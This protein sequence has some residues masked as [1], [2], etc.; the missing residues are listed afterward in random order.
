MTKR[1]VIAFLTLVF[2]GAVQA[3]SLEIPHI[4]VKGTASKDVTPDELYWRLSVRN[5]AKETQTVAKEH[6]KIVSNVIRYLKKQGIKGKDIQ[7]TNMRLAEN[8]K[9]H[10]GKTVR[11]GYYATSQISFK[12]TKLKKYVEL[13]EGLAE[14]SQVSMNGFNYSHSKADEIKSKL[15][16]E[17]LINAKVK[18]M[19]MAKT[20]HMN[21]GKPIAINEV[22]VAPVPMRTERVMMSAGP[23]SGQ[24]LSPGTISFTMTVDVIFKLED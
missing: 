24:S 1:L 7:T 3:S 19:K 4:S 21:A 20:L 17:A 9:H 15:Q 23:R 2:S 13:W 6:S 11:E 8:T 12:L 22:S 5:E 14:Y 16:E 10:K 18:A